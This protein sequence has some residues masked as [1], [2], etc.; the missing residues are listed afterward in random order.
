MAWC[1]LTAA[2]LGAAAAAGER[3][4]A[5]YGRPV[6]W[7]WLGSLL[8][9]LAAPAALWLAPEPAPA[10]EKA[11]TAQAGTAADDG[12]TVLLNLPRELVDAGRPVLPTLDRPLLAGW[13]L[14]SAALLAATCGLGL[15][16]RRRRR[17]WT[18]TT[19]DGREVLVSPDTGPAVVGLLRSAIVLPRWALEAPGEVRALMLA[20]EEEHLRAGDPRLL[21]AGLVVAVTMP[22]NP[23]VWWQLRRLRLAVEVDC[24]RRVLRGRGDVR[25]YGTLLLEIGRRASSGPLAVAAFSEPISF[26]ERRIRTMTTPRARSPFVRAAAFGA[27]AALAVVAACE[28]PRPGRINPVASEA[29]YTSGEGAA[30]TVQIVD[31]DHVQRL[32]A[33]HFPEVLTRGMQG[34]DYLTLVLDAE[35]RV[36]RSAA[37]KRPAI[38]DPA[39]GVRVQGQVSAVAVTGSGQVQGQVRRSETGS[40]QVQGQLSE[41]TVTGT[42]QQA[43]AR[44]PGGGLDDLSPDD[45]QTVNISKLEAGRVGPDAVN[46]IM[47]VMKPGFSLEASAHAAERRARGTGQFRA[48]TAGQGQRTG[49]TPRGT[50]EAAVQRYFPGAR[51]EAPAEPLVFV[52]D[53]AGSVL[54]SG[55][56]MQA[57]GVNGLDAARIERVEVFKGEQGIKA[58]PNPVQVVWITVKDGAAAAPSGQNVVVRAIRN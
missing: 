22:W 29:V 56:G 2:L 12:R 20:H 43:R 16:L 53:A 28:A 57:P 27:V 34:N 48:T 14:S 49:A 13:A 31:R 3:A 7:V 24:D 10:V 19:V 52:A 9:S 54:H 37:G 46:V 15:V 18:A 39:P 17:R 44:V 42:G 35:G 36:L 5:A 58:G 55:V 50:I 38:A 40:G 47:V 32:V 23:A 33:E 8:L 4:L 51:T 26:L 11:A 41:V 6:R 30:T 25:A 1:A 21:L 45:I